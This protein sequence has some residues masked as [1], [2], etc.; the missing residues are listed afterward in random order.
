MRLED[1]GRNPKKRKGFKSI[2]LPIKG[3]YIWKSCGIEKFRKSCFKKE[4]ELGVK[5]PIGRPKI[6]IA[7]A[8]ITGAY[9][10]RRLSMKGLFA[11]L[12][13]LPNGTKCGLTPCAWGT[14]RGFHEL[15]E[16]CDLSPESYI[17][18]KPGH[19][20]VD[21][22]RIDADMMTIDKPRLIKDLLHGATVKRESPDIT[23]YDRVIDATGLSRSFL[24]PIEK[25]LLLPCIQYRVK[26]ETRLENRIRLG[27]VGYA[28]CF[29]LSNGTYH[30]GCGSLLRNPVDVLQSLGW[31]KQ[32]GIKKLCDC[33]S[34]IRL[35]GPGQALPFVG[36]GPPEGVWGIGEGIGCVAP[37]AGDGI[38][39]GM[40]TVKLLLN[41]WDDPKGYEKAVLN[42]FSWM[43][44]ERRVVN[45]LV[46]GSVLN[47]RDARV[48]KN[49]SRRVGMRLGLTDAALI[50]K[51]L[52]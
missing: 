43:E 21:E 32:D 17:L 12:F 49:N 6:A 29:P 28:W 37:L 48:L 8:G 2:S 14:S 44:E 46:E 1:Y 20:R 41:Y 26:S 51:N 47:L 36:D 31:L 5:I 45:K 38:V 19:V 30:I 50:L 23:R 52:Q 3:W 13:D 15:V 11:D 24:P 18:H 10:Y 4:M 25:D 40:D 33:G 27:G 9:L 16:E 39:T 22:V 34:M 42:E 35:T 7:G